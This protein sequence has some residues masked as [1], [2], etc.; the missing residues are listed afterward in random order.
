[1]KPTIAPLILVFPIFL[2][3]CQSRSGAWQALDT[4]RSQMERHPDSALH[5]LRSLEPELLADRAL[6]A[7]YALLYSQA[8]DKNYIDLKSDSIIAPAVEYYAKHGRA[9]DRAYTNYYLGCIRSNAGD[10]DGAV[11][12]MIAAE[13]YASEARNTYLLARIYSSLGNMYK[14]QHSFEDADTMYRKAEACFL[15]E[16]DMVNVG[17]VISNKA[18]VYSLMDESVNSEAE[19]RKALNIFDS[20]GNREQ[21]SVLTR[22]MV[23]EMRKN[24]SVPVDTLKYLLLNAYS[25]SDIKAIP[26]A[27]YSFWVWI[28]S[29]ENNLD[30]ARYFGEQALIVENKTPNKR[31]G[32]LLQLC[33]IEELSGNYR[34]ATDYWHEYYALY[35][36]VAKMEREQ[37]IQK[38]EKRYRNQELKYTNEL[39]RIKNRYT[40]IGWGIVSLVGFA[41]LGFAFVRITRRYRQFINVLSDNYD[42]FKARYM[43]LLQEM[44]RNSAEENNLLAALERKLHVFQQLLDKAYSERKP[45]VFVSDFKNYITALGEDK[46]AFADLHY[47][48]NK[49]CYGL[50]DYLRRKH[51]ELTDYELDMLCMLR[52]GFSFDCIRLLH[53]HNNIYSLYSRRTKIHRKLNLPPR[54]SLESYLA[55]LVEKLKSGTIS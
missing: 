35:D 22:R 41:A 19:Y 25:G 10:L 20:L 28:Y 2:I 18:I 42:S 45:H 39:L 32:I 52:F 21:V 6:K 1:M 9:K 43:Q 50:V 33:R 13:S 14:S 11:R 29:H 15:A 49:R 27:D 30:S 34:K 48:I 16:N 7:R 31:C 51:P 5:I 55:E 12:A 44:D 24:N 40:S 4:A 17:Y 37:F 36:S 47:V 54:Y 23:N 26:C 8:L 38:L 3:T 53:H 46:A